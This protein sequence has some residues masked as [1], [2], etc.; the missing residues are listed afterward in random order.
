MNLGW[1]FERE[2]ERER[3]RTSIKHDKALGTR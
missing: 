1:G 3:E 2:R